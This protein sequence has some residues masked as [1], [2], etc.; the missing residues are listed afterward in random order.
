MGLGLGI[1]QYIPLLVYVISIFVLFLT[2]FYRLELGVCYLVF[3]IPLQTLL[4]KLLI[5]P[6]GKDFLDVFVVVMLIKWFLDKKNAGEPFFEKTS[7]NLPIF[8]LILWTYVALWNGSY[9]IGLPYPTDFRDWRVQEWKSWIIMYLFYFTIVNNFKDKRQIN[10][11][12]LALTVSYFVAAFRSHQL[13]GEVRAAGYFDYGLRASGTFSYLNANA[14][15]AFLSQYAVL[16]MT[17][18]LVDKMKWRRLAF[19]AISC[20][21]FYSL[22]FTFSRGGYLAT[23]VAL[24]F[25]GVVKSRILLA[26]LMI[27]LLIWDDILPVAV[28]HRVNM[29]VTEEGELEGSAAIRFSLWEQVQ[30]AIAQRPVAGLGFSTTPYLRLH[31]ESGLGADK[32]AGSTHSGYIAFLVELGVIGLLLQL[33]QFGLGMRIGWKLFKNS[34]DCLYQGIGLGLVA[35]I[36][37]ILASNF[38]SDNWR[39]MNIMGFYWVLL[40]IVTRLELDLE[41]S[42]A[43]L[44]TARQTKPQSNHMALMRRRFKNILSFEK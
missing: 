40:A 30:G 38:T 27:F 17:L 29:T 37:A 5:Y 24:I 32:T 41:S 23:I 42:D 11:L 3:F 19:A 26:V 12:I 2:L 1:T 16:F 36:L 20:L 8:L 7:L 14:F 22:L 44:Q 31:S 10:M 28:V 9:N 4:D 43:V 33:W 18:F 35:C 13:S 25:L 6:L 34:K 39:I 21:G 15:G